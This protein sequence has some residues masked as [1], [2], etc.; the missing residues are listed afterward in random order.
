MTTDVATATWWRK[1]GGSVHAVE[2]P[3]FRTS[4]GRYVW[5]AAWRRDDGEAERC[6]TCVAV[7]TPSESE[8]RELH[9][10]R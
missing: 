9:G 5:T 8:E 3:R 2:A 6:Q 1:P 7:L 4:C 10:G